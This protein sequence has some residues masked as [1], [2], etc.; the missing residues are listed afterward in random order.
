ME[1][2]YRKRRP[3]RIH[4]KLSGSAATSDVN[5]KPPP[6]VIASARVM[7]Y[8]YVDDIPYRKRGGLYR[9][10]QRLHRVPRL[11]V[12][13]NLGRNIGPLLVHCDHDWNP[14]GTSGAATIDAVKK[15]AAESYPGVAARWVDVNTSVEDALEYYDGQTQGLMCSF[16]GKRP[17]EI[18]GG[19]VKGV[20]AAI[21]RDCVE[22]CYRA[23]REPDDAARGS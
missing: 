22:D 19:L 7:S 20:D 6:P 1:P 16:C 23:F 12:C 5:R 2:N 9:D 17:F 11:A 14:L 10:G 3:V 4:G 21:C 15:L 18:E 8:A 13:I